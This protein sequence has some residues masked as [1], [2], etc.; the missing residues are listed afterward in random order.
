V[1]RTPTIVRISLLAGKIYSELLSVPP[2]SL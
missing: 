1:L 2:L